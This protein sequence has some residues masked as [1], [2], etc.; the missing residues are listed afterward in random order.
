VCREWEG[1]AVRASEMGLRVVLVRTGGVLSLEGGA[2]QKMLRPFKLG[3]AG[4]LG[5][6]R[7]WFP[8][9][10]IDDIVEIFRLALLN[11]SLQGAVNGT[12]PEPVTN[13]E[14]TR[15]LAGAL[16]RPAFLP[17]PEFG[18]RALMGEMS[19][20]LLMSQRVVPKVALGA[21]YKFLHPTLGDAL[22]DLLGE[23]KSGAQKA[24]A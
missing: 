6:G 2:L 14:F 8:W 24:T 13:G 3:L 7:Q 19:D 10:H 11:E 4:K 17:V 1:E 5:S 20:V 9:I 16:H 15:M 21:G 23:K 12:A 22:G 18:L